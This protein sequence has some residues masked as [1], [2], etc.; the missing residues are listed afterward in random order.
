M[1]EATCQTCPN[2]TRNTEPSYDW[3]LCRTKKLPKSISGTPYQE[4]VW[5]DTQEDDWCAEH[6]DRQPEHKEVEG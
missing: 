1:S 3:G 5:P 4:T 6:P 2:W